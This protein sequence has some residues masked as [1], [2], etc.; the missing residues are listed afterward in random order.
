[1]TLS[2][3]GAISP[4]KTK[5]ARKGTGG[6]GKSVFSLRDERESPREERASFRG[7]AAEQPPSPASRHTGTKGSEKAA[8][9][10]GRTPLP[11]KKG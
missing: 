11:E 7:A 3:R 1:V 2:E 9:Q 10:K 8:I 5:E 4:F 6:D